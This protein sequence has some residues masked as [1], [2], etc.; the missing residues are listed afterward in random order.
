MISYSEPL[1]LYRGGV[2]FGD[3]YSQFTGIDDTS[4]VGVIE[5]DDFAVLTN[6]NGGDMLY[7]IAKIV[8][9]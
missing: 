3:H 8:K 4:P 2:R 1:K 7:T 5:G 6:P 9:K